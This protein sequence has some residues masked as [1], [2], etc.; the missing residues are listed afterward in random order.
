MLKKTLK[1]ACALAVAATFSATAAHADN[2][3][4]LVMDGGF[5]PAVSYVQPGDN[6]IFTNNSEGEITMSDVNGSWT[7]DP[8]AIEGRFVLNITAN[9]A[10]QFT[11][12]G[13]QE[14]N[15]NDVGNDYQEVSVIGEISFD[16][17]PL[18]QATE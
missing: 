8:I 17:A 5:F 3:T 18:D 6:V 12:S 1:G 4:V 11:A 7:S 16:P 15:D 2:H 13:L 10:M 14:V 9:S